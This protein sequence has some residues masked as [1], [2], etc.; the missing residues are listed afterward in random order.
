LFVCL[1]L[2]TSFSI[3]SSEEEDD[4][5]EDSSAN[6]PC[7]CR[8]PDAENADTA[9]MADRVLPKGF[10]R[11]LFFVVLFVLWPFLL[12]L[13]VSASAGAGAPKDD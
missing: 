3:P 11:G 8:L 2:Y 10:R 9:E 7:A 4:D 6:W 12:L 5:E 13:A 1:E